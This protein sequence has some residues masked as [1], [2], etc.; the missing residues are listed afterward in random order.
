MKESQK[1]PPTQEEAKKIEEIIRHNMEQGAWG[2]F[3]ILLLS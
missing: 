2:N 1:R 3:I